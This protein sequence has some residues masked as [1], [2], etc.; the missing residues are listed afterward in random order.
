MAEIEQLKKRIVE[1]ESK[2]EDV[3]ASSTARPKIS[4]MS[5]EVVDSNPYRYFTAGLF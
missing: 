1:L 5:A 4:H 3:K 2:L